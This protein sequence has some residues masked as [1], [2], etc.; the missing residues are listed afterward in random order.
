MVDVTDERL[1]AALEAL[2]KGTVPESSWRHVVMTLVGGLFREMHALR[3]DIT[4]IKE[5]TPTKDELSAVQKAM[6]DDKFWSQVGQRLARYAKASIVGTALVLGIWGVYE[7]L[8]K[9]KALLAAT[10]GGR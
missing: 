2:E 4:D 1:Q 9:V 10:G 6:E 7:V 8:V 5:R 3:K